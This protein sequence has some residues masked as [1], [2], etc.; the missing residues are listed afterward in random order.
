MTETRLIDVLCGISPEPHLLKQFAEPLLV[1]MIP[2]DAGAACTGDRL[3]FSFMGEVVLHFFHQ[4]IPGAVEDDFF[5]RLEEF[6]QPRRPT[7]QLKTAAGGN[8][9]IPSLDLRAVGRGSA[10]E[11]QI[12]A[13]RL[14]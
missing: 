11:I 1:R 8:F 7:A 10:R 4:L 12:D 13:A 5:V 3:A 6:F 9:K 14:E 2:E